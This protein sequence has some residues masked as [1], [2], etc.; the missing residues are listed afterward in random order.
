MGMNPKKFRE[1]ITPAG[2]VMIEEDELCTQHSNHGE[3]NVRPADED[4]AEKVKDSDESET[5][6]EGT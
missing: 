1:M 3:A 2:R 5:L 4:A 6:D